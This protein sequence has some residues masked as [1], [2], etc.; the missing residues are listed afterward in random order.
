MLYDVPSWL[1]WILPLISSM[2]VPLIA[3]FGGKARNYFAVTVSL[4]TAALA[5]SL[6]PDVY[7]GSAGF[8]D[9]STPWIPSSGI[10]AG[11]LLDPLSVL[12]TVLVAFFVLV[13]SIYS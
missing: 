5:F 1:V 7:F 4:I 12:F 10:T 6:I 9:S 8:F 13:I 11:V 2:F 3:R